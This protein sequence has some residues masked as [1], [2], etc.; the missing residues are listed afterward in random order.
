MIEIPK[1][2]RREFADEI[3]KIIM[4]GKQEFVVAVST[5]KNKKNFYKVLSNVSEEETIGRIEKTKISILYENYC[6]KESNNETY[7]AVR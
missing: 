5:S 2:L 4:D 6:E 7:K 3:Y 1:Q